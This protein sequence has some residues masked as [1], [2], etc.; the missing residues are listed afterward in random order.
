[1][2]SLKISNSDFGVAKFVITQ[3]YSL[4]GKERIPMVNVEG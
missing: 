1:M 4:C 2:N 3:D